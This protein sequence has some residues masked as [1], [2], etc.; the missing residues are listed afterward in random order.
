M[1][2]VSS[3]RCS[4]QIEDLLKRDCVFLDQEEVQPC[5]PWNGS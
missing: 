2:V 4:K 5:F 3:G 1:C